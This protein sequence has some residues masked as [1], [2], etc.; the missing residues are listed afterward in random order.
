MHVSSTPLRWVS[1]TLASAATAA[2]VGSVVITAALS[3]A[4]WNLADLGWLLAVAGAVGLVGAVVL[5]VPL[6]F[7]GSW[8]K[9][10]SRAALPPALLVIIG[11][12]SYL[13]K[14]GTAWSR[15]GDRQLEVLLIWCSLLAGQVLHS[16]LLLRTPRSDTPRRA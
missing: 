11:I 2:I 5:F 12:A 3:D 1:A 16:W 8:V 14:F 6:T 10:P 13:Y 7:L 4:W 15:H 9:P